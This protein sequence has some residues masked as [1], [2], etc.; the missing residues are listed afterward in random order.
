MITIRHLET[1]ERR[2]FAS[3]DGVDLG[4]W[5]PTDEPVPDDL[6]TRAYVTIEGGL[7]PKP[8][9]ERG[10]RKS[11]FLDL[12]TPAETVAV[13]QSADPLMAYFWARTLAWDGLFLLSDS[14]IIAGAMHALSLNILTQARADHILAGLPPA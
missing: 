4:V 12:W 1:D 11:E 6:E 10:F 8:E 3:L 7:V 5:E 2:F 9:P 14:R 13:M